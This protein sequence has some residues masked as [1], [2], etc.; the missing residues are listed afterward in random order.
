M[1]IVNILTKFCAL[2]YTSNLSVYSLTTLSQECIDNCDHKMNAIS[3]I[4]SLPNLNKRLLLYLIRF[5]KVSYSL[6]SFPEQA[7]GQVPLALFPKGHV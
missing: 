6:T 4:G 3:L 1:S 2:R 5:L 7:W